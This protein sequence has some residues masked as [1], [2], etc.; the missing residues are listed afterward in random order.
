MP[1]SKVTSF[2]RQLAQRYLEP[3]SKTLFRGL[4]NAGAMTFSPLH[5]EG[6]RAGCHLPPQRDAT[7]LR[8]VAAMDARWLARIARRAYERHRLAAPIGL[9]FPALAEIG[10]SPSS[11]WPGCSK[12]SVFDRARNLG[13]WDS[14]RDEIE[15]RYGPKSRVTQQEQKPVQ[16]R[17]QKA[18]DSSFVLHGLR[19]DAHPVRQPDRIDRLDI[20]QGI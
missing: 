13:Y 20:D 6:L 18:H 19:M 15:G 2:D 7:A 16:R 9:A 17:Q 1:A 8:F 4:L 10:L 14:G 12:A 5:D 11:K 3:T